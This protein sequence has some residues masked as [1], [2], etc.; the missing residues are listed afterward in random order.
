[1]LDII[2]SNDHQ[3]ALGV[4]DEGV[5]NAKPRLAAAGRARQTAPPAEQKTIE[6]YQNKRANKRG[7]GEACVEERL[8]LPE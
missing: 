6:E 4:E 5:D 1:M 3:L 2:P 7:K 8:I